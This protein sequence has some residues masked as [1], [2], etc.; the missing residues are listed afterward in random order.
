MTLGEALNQ[1]MAQMNANLRQMGDGLMQAGNGFYQEARRFVR[2]FDE[3][4]G[5]RYRPATISLSVNFPTV[6]NIAAATKLAGTADFRVA[7]NED[8]LVQSTRT[9]LVQKDLAN[10]Q[11]PT[12]VALGAALNARQRAEAKA[13]NTR[14]NI[15]NK[16]TKVPIM[17][18]ENLGF[19]TTTPELSGTLLAFSPDI[20]PGFIIPHNMT[21]QFQVFL[22]SNTDI[23]LV[24][25]ST[26]YGVTMTG[27]YIS[28]D[29]G[30]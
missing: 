19:A 12:N 18:N 2:A 21:V 17:E 23:S 8:F 26:D 27:V 3:Q 28:R 7:Q 20:V 13:F 4:R 15:I 10:A 9:F 25:D 30:R 16:D 1:N 14:Y 24:G 5:L 11:A 29:I 6:P 22:Q